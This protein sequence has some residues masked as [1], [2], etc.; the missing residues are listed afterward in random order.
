MTTLAQT[1]SVLSYSKLAPTFH[2]SDL[3][4]DRARLVYGLV[5]KMNMDVGTMISSQISQIAQSN[6]SRLGFSTLII[7]LCEARG[8]VSNFLTFES[9]SLTI[10][11]AYIHKNCWNPADPSI[12]FLRS[13]KARTTTLAEAPPVAPPP[14]RPSASSFS[15][16]P[17]DQLVPMLQSIH[18]GSA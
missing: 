15:S 6:S 1:W 11:L 9:L 7:A 8:V 14:P 4:M 2:T 18:D 3:N 12:T 17:P 5:I 13:R 16:T 10:N